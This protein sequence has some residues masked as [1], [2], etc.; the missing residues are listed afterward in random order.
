M[1]YLRLH[2][3]V[4]M[5]SCFDLQNSNAQDL[6]VF[7]VTREMG[8]PGKKEPKNEFIGERRYLEMG[9][10]F[11]WAKDSILNLER[12]ST[13][14]FT[15]FY[16][17]N[18]QDEYNLLV[19]K[20]IGRKDCDSFV[21]QHY[22]RGIKGKQL[23]K[24]KTNYLKISENEYGIIGCPDLYRVTIEKAERKD[25]EYPED[26]EDIDLLP[27]YEEKRNIVKR[28]YVYLCF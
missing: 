4:F 1:R 3:L 20:C 23:K 2:I 22:Q 18:W 19:E 7:A 24:T 6:E 21:V 8:Y 14:Y 9:S 16:I 28:F 12:V 27:E 26:P 10:S 25:I 15:D 5:F 13:S 17:F 11:E